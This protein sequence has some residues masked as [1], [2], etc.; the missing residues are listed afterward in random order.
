MENT[1]ILAIYG[2]DYKEM[3]KKLLEEADLASRIPDKECRIGIK[4]NLVSPSEPSWALPP[5][6][7]LWQE[8]LNI[9]RNGDSGILLCWKV[10]GWGTRRKIRPDSADI[11]TFQK[12]T[13]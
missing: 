5:I 2:T 13:G 12:N 6:R 8:S 11:M 1:E 7:R 10:P 9:F 4:P 3:T